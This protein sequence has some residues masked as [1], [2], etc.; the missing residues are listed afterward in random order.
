VKGDYPEGSF[1]SCCPFCSWKEVVRGKARR[2][3]SIQ[4][5]LGFSGRKQSPPEAKKSLIQGRS[6]SYPTASDVLR[7]LSGRAVS[8][9]AEE[10]GALER[11][12]IVGKYNHT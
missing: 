1:Q 11:V 4:R 6:R 5:F 7:I 9:D 10:A 8:P 2:V 12:V 3:L